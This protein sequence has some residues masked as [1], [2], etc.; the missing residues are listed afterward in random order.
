M[1]LLKQRKIFV[2][3]KVKAIAMGITLLLL[4]LLLLGFW[5]KV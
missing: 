5:F 4:L 3:R 1:K 2:V